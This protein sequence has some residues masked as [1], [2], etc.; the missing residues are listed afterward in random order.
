M[1][2]NSI[3]IH[4]SQKNFKENS[5]SFSINC[6]NYANS[7]SKE[8][9]PNNFNSKSISNTQKSIQNFIISQDNFEIIPNSNNFIQNNNNNQNKIEITNQNINSEKSVQNKKKFIGEGGFGKLY[10]Y[11]KNFNLDVVDKII[12]NK[13]SYEKEVKYL[14]KLKKSP[15]HNYIVE[16]YENYEENGNYHIIMEKCNGNLKDLMNKKFKNGF[17][18]NIVQKITKIIIKVVKYLND[19]LNIFHNDIKTKNI[20]YKIFG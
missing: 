2:T 9:Y 17:P 6:N 12:K 18:L 14:N 1:N 3:E 8:F 4:E 7:E 20:L 15:I 11:K 5:Y 16:I 10:T 19:E 13:E